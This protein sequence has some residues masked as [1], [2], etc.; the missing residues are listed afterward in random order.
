M[1]AS[2]PRRADVVFRRGRVVDGTGAPVIRADVAVD[3]ERIVAVGDL[4]A[5]SGGREIDAGGR[6]VAPGFIDV[7]THDDRALVDDGA[8]T[9]KIS[10]GV[11]T[12]VA[13]NCGISLA[14]FEASGWPPPPL[15]LL[16]D[17]A[18]YR[19]SAFGAYVEALE[20][21]PPA[22]NP[23]LLVG[24]TTLRHRHLADVGRP[25]TDRELAAMTT[26]VGDA[27]AAGAVGLS[28]GLDYPAARPAPTD[29]VVHLA[30][31]A[32][33]HGGLYVTHTRDY[34]G[35]VEEA[36]EEAF[37]IGRRAD[38]P[39]ILSHHQVSGAANFGRS[40][41]TLARIDTVRSEQPVGLDAY[42][43]AA[44]SKTLDPER[45]RP[46]T[47]VVVTWSEPHP[48]AVGY[49]VD[50]IAECWQVPPEEAAERLLPAG[51]VY[52]QLDESDVH[53]ILAY[54][55]TMI[56]SDGLPGDA[57]PHPRLWGT[58]PRV[59][60]HYAR[61]VGLFT[62]EE[63]VRKMTAL[64]AAE[65]GLAGR[66]C[67]RAGAFADIVVFD[68]E[69]IADTATYDEPARQAAGIDLVMV[70]GT[71]VWMDGSPTG[72]RPGRVLRRN[73]LDGTDEMRECPA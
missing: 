47:R 7:H 56:G 15:D 44:S 73:A 65:F 54:P 12:V 20:T 45:C 9:P 37:T 11:T 36:L 32:G 21:Q 31:A 14:P 60:G 10:Q 18:G 50:E 19:F 35:N 59:L 3:G 67:L 62:L 52:F 26:T 17:G 66:G 46:G 28:T 48:E 68:P 5:T 13:G 23:A 69:T 30:A 43:Y 22:T 16:G 41:R 55:P 4:A 72:A 57:K 70:N 27:M 6:I 71:I 58:F 64:P 38:V 2:A 29:E 25:A 61:D 33:A 1:T 63:A 34:F 42:P 53:R 40:R 51:A 24:H 39:V 49:E 8:M